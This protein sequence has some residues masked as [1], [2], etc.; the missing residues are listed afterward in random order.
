MTINLPRHIFV[1]PDGNGRWATRKGLSRLNGHNEGAKRFHEIADTVFRLDVPYF[2]FWALSADNFL[3][4]ELAEI[5][6]IFSLLRE[7]LEEEF[8][9]KLMTSKVC[10]RVIGRWRDMIPDAGLIEMI[11]GL[12]NR[13][14]YFKEKNLTILLGYGGKDE[15]VEAVKNMAR[16]GIN[17]NMI[18]FNE[19]RNFS[20]TRELPPVDLEIR[21]GEEKERFAHRSDGALPFLTTDSVLYYTKTLWPD[22]K[23]KEFLEAVNGYATFER[24]FGAATSLPRVMAGGEK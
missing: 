22:F 15:A 2:T 10:L 9:E 11:T 16:S 20:I 24:K 4:R 12:K 23:E 14:R 1:T 7:T 8:A 17:P 13:T 18:D 3:K 6:H 5:K 21:T 19:W